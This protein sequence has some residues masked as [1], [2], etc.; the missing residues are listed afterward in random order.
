MTQFI[1]IDPGSVNLGLAVFQDE[2]LL[3]YEAY[4]FHKE[5]YVR[6]PLALWEA[7][8]AIARRYR[9]EEVAIESATR[10]RAKSGM[11]SKIPELEVAV[12]T[13]KRWAKSQHCLFREHNAATW[14]KGFAGD[15]RADKAAVARIV[16]LMW[17]KLPPELPDHVT[18]A[19]GIGSFHAGLR[20]LEKLA[21]Q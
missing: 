17:P 12:S 16:Y 8:E 3:Y 5:E 11:V 20:R 13:I 6:R 15:F 19:I 14:R 4:D 21:G 9:V 1:A 2:A 10:R 18:D 7:L